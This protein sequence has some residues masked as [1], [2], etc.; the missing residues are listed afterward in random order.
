MEKGHF[1]GAEEQL[2]TQLWGHG[3]PMVTDSRESRFPEQP[4]LA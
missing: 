1:G 2:V 4:S 3:Q